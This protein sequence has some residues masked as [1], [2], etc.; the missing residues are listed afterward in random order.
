MYKTIEAIYE[1]GKIL[2]LKEP[3]NIKKAR[4]LITIINE[5]S[6][7]STSDKNNESLSEDDKSDFFSLAGIWENRKTDTSDLRK[8]AW[9]RLKK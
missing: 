1:D 2:D 7:S 4:I 8:E 5:I 6:E 9:G 3:L